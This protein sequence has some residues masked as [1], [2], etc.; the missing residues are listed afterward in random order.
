M[1]CPELFLLRHGETEWNLERRLQGQLDSPLTEQGILQAR[2]QAEI[3]SGLSL[4]ADLRAFCSPLGRARQTA[5]IALGPLG[6]NPDLE[7]G[8]SEVGLGLWQGVCWDD[9]ARR[10]PKLY[11]A[12]DNFFLRSLAAPG[13]ESHA[14]ILER[15][16]QFLGR[17]SGPAVIVSHGV[18]LNVLRG[19]ACDLH[20]EEQA[21]LT[22]A[23]GVVFH[24]ADG[25]ETM[26][27]A[28][29]KGLRSTRLS[30]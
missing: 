6:L 20:L 19:L 11:A 24:I 10:W 13:G 4:P 8:L 30:M 5:E 22:Q 7:P 25:K 28:A 18:V 29:Q 9:I 27:E 26:L 2:Q 3:L 15:L 16:L 14:A 1:T 12:S 17:L 23:Q 21:Q